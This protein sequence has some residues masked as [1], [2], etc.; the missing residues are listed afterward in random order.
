MDSTQLFF[1]CD[2]MQCESRGNVFMLSCLVRCVNNVQRSY[3][4]NAVM[5]RSMCVS[6]PAAE[7]NVTKS[8]PGRLGG[9]YYS[10]ENLLAVFPQQSGWPI[11]SKALCF[12]Q[13]NCIA[14]NS[15][16]QQLDA[17][18]IIKPPVEESLTIPFLV[19]WIS[20]HHLLVMKL[21]SVA[22][23]FTELCWFCISYYYSGVFRTAR[24]LNIIF[25]PSKPNMICQLVIADSDDNR[26]EKVAHEECCS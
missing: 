10:L 7:N 21:C 5:W 9:V 25:F 16:L 8:C 6:G 24:K 26:L 12:P 13:H 17:G 4:E 23:H 15:V 11:N 22:P 20:I 2:L 18:L 3:R 14:C 19:A 1:R